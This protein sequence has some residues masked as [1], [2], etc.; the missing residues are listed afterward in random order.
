MDIS[1]IS[2]ALHQENDGIWYGR[3]STA[4]SYPDDGNAACFEVEDR[5]LWFTHR[6]HCIETVVSAYPPPGNG[7]IFDIGGGNGVVSAHLKERGHEVVLVEP[8][9]SGALNARHRG[10]D[11]VICATTETA[12]FHNMTLPAVGLFDVIEHIKDDRRFLRHV[13]SL[14]KVDGRLYATV[15]AYPVLWSAE[16]EAAGH[17]R[18]YT[19]T[20]LC[21][22]LEKSG[23]RIEFATYIF[24]YLPLPI[25]LLRSLPYRLLGRKQRHS[26]NKVQRDHSTRNG[27][28]RNSLNRVLRSELNSL[29]ALRPLKFGASCL[30]V[31]TKVRPDSG[32]RAE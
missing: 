8:G 1:E 27:V 17:F 18:R 5:S 6:N 26:P 4:V 21:G 16:D 3:S 23:L 2:T 14:L 13:Y 25:F 9:S 31:A 19:L 32:G 15:P 22:L 12:D 20:E 7:A 30:V 24:K 29:R 28:T 11:T 10:I